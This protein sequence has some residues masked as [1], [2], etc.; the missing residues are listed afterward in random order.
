[1]VQWSSRLSNNMYEILT[2]FE[3]DITKN[4]NFKIF[5]WN[6]YKTITDFYN[7]TWHLIYL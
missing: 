7:P 4:L 5:Q 3:K 2:L 6:S 1:M